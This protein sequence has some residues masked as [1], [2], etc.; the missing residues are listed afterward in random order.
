MEVHPVGAGSAPL[1][2]LDFDGVICDSVEECWV[3]SW[4]AYHELFLGRAP[5]PPPRDAAADA[6][7]RFRA[8]RPYIRSGEDFVLIQQLITRGASPRSQAEFDREW[9][10]LGAPARQQFKELYYRARTALFERDPDAWLAMNRIFAHVPAALAALSPR[11][12][13]YILSTKK[14]Q[15]VSATLRANDL[16]VAEGRVLYSEEEP[17]LTTV[18]RLMRELPAR[19]AVF[20][21]DQVDALRA[22]RNPR[23]HTYLATWGYVQE[24]WLRDPGNG[25]NLLD[26]EGFVRLLASL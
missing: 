14:T 12:P 8:L 3:S 26:P 17:K 9:E 25:V 2:V 16:S 13:L 18:E 21:E 11:V 1:L 20:V 10:R 5:S 19:E 24:E 6:R 15:F 7:V 22:N 4:T 23:L